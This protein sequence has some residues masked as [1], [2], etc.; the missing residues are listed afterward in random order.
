M[1][2]V[3]LGVK[4]LVQKIK[5]GKM[6]N[7]ENISAV[8]SLLIKR[9]RKAKNMTQ[10]QLAQKVGLSTRHIGKLEDGTYLPKFVTYLKLAQVLQFDASEIEKL[11]QI[12]T[13]KN[14]TKLL[15]LLQTMRPEEIDLSIEMMELLVKRRANA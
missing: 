12:S 3:Y 6:I 13:N 1:I 10:Q 11:A 4:Q 2:F 8:L 5:R 9:Q 7:E 15:L 14:E